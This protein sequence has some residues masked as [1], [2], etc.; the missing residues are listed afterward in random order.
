MLKLR[1]SDEN[2]G[3]NKIWIIIFGHFLGH[4]WKTSFTLVWDTFFKGIFEE[5]LWNLFIEGITWATSWGLHC[6]AYSFHYKII[7]GFVLWI[8]VSSTW[9]WM[10]FIF[11]CESFIFFSLAQ[12]SSNFGF[13]SRLFISFH[14][15]FGRGLLTFTWSYFLFKKLKK[16]IIS[17]FFL[18]F[19]GFL[20]FH[21]GF[22]I[23]F[24][25]KSLFQVGFSFPFASFLKFYWRVSY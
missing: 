17:C 1:I 11:T 23:F 21:V 14:F 24:L 19:L 18:L 22:R 3:W 4:T 12:G 5:C 10:N 8:R 6:L 9:I 20:V 16:K 2:R 25:C 7:L 13:F 15:H